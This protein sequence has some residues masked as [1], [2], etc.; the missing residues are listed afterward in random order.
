MISVVLTR[1][2]K[3][4]RCLQHLNCSLRH[5]RLELPVF[6]QVKCAVH[7]S[8]SHLETYS[9]SKYRIGIHS[10]IR[11]SPCSFF[12]IIKAENHWAMPY[13]VSVYKAFSHKWPPF[14]FDPHRSAIRYLWKMHLPS[15]FVDEKTKAWIIEETWARPNGSADITEGRALGLLFLN[16]ILE[17]LFPCHTRKAPLLCSEP[18]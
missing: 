8:H 1:A 17:A 3:Q 16:P 10:W 12:C 4:F 5:L 18:P 9:K 2:D 6:L 13:A 7:P 14:Y 11:I 15:C